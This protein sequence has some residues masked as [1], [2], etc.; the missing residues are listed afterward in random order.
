[1]ARV[2]DKDYGLIT[3]LRY[4]IWIPLYPL[5]F[6]CEGVVILRYHFKHLQ[7]VVPRLHLSSIPYLK[8]CP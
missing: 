8:C 7:Y 6:L 2:Y 3:W 4:T 1:M 5:G